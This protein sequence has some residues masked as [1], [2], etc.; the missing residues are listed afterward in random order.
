MDDLLLNNS[1]ENLIVITLGDPGGIS[2]EILIK[3]LK[4]NKNI[5]HKKDKILI[6]GSFDIIKFYSKQYK[7]DIDVKLIIE[8]EKLHNINYLFNLF[9][10][11]NILLYDPFY[12]KSKITVNKFN[13]M[14]YK[15]YIKQENLVYKDNKKIKKDLNHTNKIN[16][17]DVIKIGKVW[18]INGFFSE[19]YLYLSLLFIKNL[20]KKRDIDEN[21]SKGNNNLNLSKLNIT[22]LTLPVNKKAISLVKPGFIGHTEYIAKFFK[23]KNYTMTMYSDK[24]T[25]MLVTTHI[26]LLKLKKY[27][28]I[29]NFTKTLKNAILFYKIMN[30]KNG[31]GV[32]S[33]NPHAS[34][35][36][37]IGK[38]ERWIKMLIDRFNIGNVNKK[39]YNNNTNKNYDDDYTNLVKDNNFNNNNDANNSGNNDNNNKNNNRIIIEGPIPSD[40]AFAQ[41]SNKKY[42]IYIA[43]YH[44]QGLIPFKLLA[45]GKG[46]NI[47]FGLPFLRIS[48]DHG[49]GFDIV[50]KNIAKTD[51]LDKCFEVIE[52]S[53]KYL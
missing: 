21:I 3:S 38:E 16:F 45:E 6:F 31:I 4:N 22:L 41:Y 43:F 53:N 5:N 44:D 27:I 10:Q 11:N 1:T 17:F 32:L 23:V 13:L 25:V 26:P 33:L 35:G 19:R 48:P 18:Y 40:T 39:I 47:T 14:S 24:I 50:G 15:K 37:I 36:G 29:R 42:S 2:A 28:N 30:F 9:K 52:K 20:L 8:Y 12:E 51:S 7:I 34:D 49:T 46:T